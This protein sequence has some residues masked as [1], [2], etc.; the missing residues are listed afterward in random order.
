MNTVR[1]ASLISLGFVIV[2]CLLYFTGAIGL[3]VVKWSALAGTIGWFIA[4]P[5]WMSRRLP[6]DATEVEI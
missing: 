2:P 3:D 6:V 1:I 4:T 5:V